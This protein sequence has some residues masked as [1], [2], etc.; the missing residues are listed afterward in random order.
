[1]TSRRT[2]KSWRY[3]GRPTCASRPCRRPSSTA[4]TTCSPTLTRSRIW[5]SSSSWPSIASP[6]RSRRARRSRKTKTGTW[7]SSLRA[8][9]APAKPPWAPSC[10][11][12]SRTLLART[13]R[14][15]TRGASAA[16]RTMR[17]ARWP[18][19]MCSLRCRLRMAPSLSTSQAK[20][21]L[22]L[23]ARVAPRSSKER[24]GPD[25]SRRPATAP[26]PR[27]VAPSRIS[28]V[29]P[30]IPRSPMRWPASASRSRA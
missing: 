14:S 18:S 22:T 1:M 19:A 20:S 12:R 13:S 15:S 26:L 24:T 4:W 21:S 28:T 17:R 3:A 11:T 10:A 30:W 25:S 27:I 8:R 2:P 5:T 16:T 6:R 29:S 9:S 23:S 7:T